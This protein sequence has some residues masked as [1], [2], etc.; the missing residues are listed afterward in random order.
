MASLR[1]KVCRFLNLFR[2][3]FG[4][5]IL[6]MAAGRPSSELFWPGAIFGRIIQRHFP[7]IQPGNQCPSRDDPTGQPIDDACQILAADQ[8][9]ARRKGIHFHL[10]SGPDLRLDQ[11]DQFDGFHEQDPRKIGATEWSSISEAPSRVIQWR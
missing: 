1:T 6:A 10:D 5:V 11:A 9:E 3:A 8:L 4:G 7:C 2:I